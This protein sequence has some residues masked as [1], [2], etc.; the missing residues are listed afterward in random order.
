MGHREMVATKGSSVVILETFGS[1]LS[2]LSPFP[3]CF[4]WSRPTS[5]KHLGRAIIYPW[6]S[7]RF[8]HQ[9]IL[10][11]IVFEI[12]HVIT[13]AHPVSITVLFSPRTVRLTFQLPRLIVDTAAIFRFFFPGS[14]RASIWRR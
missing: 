13:D 2:C 6:A 9:V 11:H 4:K 8:C 5:F 14:F 10:E 7:F 12:L 1:G 3:H